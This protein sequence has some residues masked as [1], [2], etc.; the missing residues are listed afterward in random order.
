VKFSNIKI[1]QNKT[2]R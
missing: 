2:A 1:T